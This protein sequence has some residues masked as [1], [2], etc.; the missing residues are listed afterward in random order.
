MKEYLLNNMKL[1][2][3]SKEELLERIGMWAR[4]NESRVVCFANVHMNIECVE[5]E[6]VKEAVN[7]ADIVCPDG[8]PLVWWLKRKGNM[9]KSDLMDHQ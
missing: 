5:S 1:H 4:K 6:K 8:M 9:T 3:I 2:S 7:S